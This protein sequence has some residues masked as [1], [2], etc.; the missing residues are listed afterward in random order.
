MGFILCNGGAKLR[1]CFVDEGGFEI[2]LLTLEDIF[3]FRSS[4]FDVGQIS[5]GGSEVD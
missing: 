2:I 4:T 1:R 3:G 5:N